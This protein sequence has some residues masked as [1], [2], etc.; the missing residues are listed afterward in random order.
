MARLFREIMSACL[1]LEKPIHA[2][3]PVAGNLHGATLKHF[4][5]SRASAHSGVED[6]FREVEAGT[7]H[8]GVVPV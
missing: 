6:V 1:A 2:T 7:V 5:R 4:G 3:L 8:Y